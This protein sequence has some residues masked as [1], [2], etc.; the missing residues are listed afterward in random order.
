MKKMKQLMLMVALLPGMAMAG[1]ARDTTFVVNKQQIVVSQEGEKTT[2][3]VYDGEGEEMKKLSET[4]FVDGQEVE[5]VYVTSP[6]IPQQ[7]RKRKRS[8]S[9]HYPTFYF[10]YSMLPGSIM[11]GGNSEM[12]SRDSKS[13][14]WG[15]TLT[16]LCVTLGNSLALTSSISW[17]QVHHHFQDNFVLSTHEGETT[18]RQVEG[19]N[20]KKSYISYK[21]VRIPLML[22]WQHRVRGSD[23]F[24]AVGPSVEFRYGDHSRY[25]IGKRKFTETHDVNLNPI[26]FNMDV[27]AGYGALMLYARTALTPLLDTGRAPKCYPFS[28]G[29]GIRL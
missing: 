5:K 22:E 1:E 23:A 17:G 11:G 14:E 9:S 27:R 28:V 15:F 4:Q 12:H 25:Y 20:L 18:M 7:F 29:L 6:F 10:G 2:V 24:L 19:E 13:W 16:S 8:L 26:G 21:V 3:K